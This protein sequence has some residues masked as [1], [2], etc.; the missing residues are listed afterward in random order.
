MAN[1]GS[2]LGG[3]VAPAGFDTWTPRHPWRLLAPGRL[4]AVLGLCLLSVACSIQDPTEGTRSVTVLNDLGYPVGI[5]ICND[6]NCYRTAGGYAT[7]PPGSTYFMN[8]IP[9][10]REA[11]KVLPEQR[12]HSAATCRTIVVGTRLKPAYPLSSAPR[13]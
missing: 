4:L 2:G 6:S 11:L 10:D 1:P 7:V 13:C 3:W 12:K 5:A 9:P 8:V